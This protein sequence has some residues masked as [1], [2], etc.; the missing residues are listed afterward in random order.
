M[1]TSTRPRAA[2]GPAAKF[3]RHRLLPLHPTTVTAVQAYRQL[4][5][6]LFPR[7]RSQALLVFSA[8]TS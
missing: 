6:R 5:D 7:P 8:G 4:R 3:G 2:A 1:T